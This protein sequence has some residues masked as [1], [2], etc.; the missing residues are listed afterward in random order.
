MA[1]KK[2]SPAPAPA[3]GEPPAAPVTASYT[4]GSTPLLLDGE[5]YESG[6]QVELTVAQARGLDVTLVQDANEE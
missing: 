3:S 1:T 6:A 4:V 5:R 2:T